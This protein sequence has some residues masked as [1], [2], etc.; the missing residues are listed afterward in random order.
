[1]ASLQTV[2][3]EMW[4]VASEDHRAGMAR[5]GIPTERAM[6]ISV[7]LLRKMARAY[8]NE[9]E[10]AIE[11]W[12]SGWHEARILAP[13]VADPNQT[14]SELVDRWTEAFDAWDIC[15]LCC[16]NLFRLTPFVYDKIYAYFPREE[17]FVRRTAFVLM[18]TLAVGDK[19]A[20]DE[21][22]QIILIGVEHDDSL[23]KS[24]ILDYENVR[25]C[26]NPI[27]TASLA[28]IEHYSLQTRRSEN[29]II[30]VGHVLPTKGIFELIEACKTIG[31]IQLH[32]IGKISETMNNNLIKLI[33]DISAEQC[34]KICGELS[35]DT[36]I[37]EMLSASVLALPS[38]T[39][40]FPNVILESMACGC[41]IIATP[42]GA[43]PEM[44]NM[45]SE[46]PCGIVVPVKNVSALHN[47][48]TTIINNKTQ[49]DSFAMRARK[50]VMQNYTT[51][52]VWE[53]LKSVWE[54]LI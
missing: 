32:I 53:N 12:N 49:A 48:I 38:Y 51:E 52:K 27:T 16:Q 19:A 47:A 14:T 23:E 15:D 18:A 2:L 40:G 7:P 26:P 35:H 9:H 25:Y 44:L 17:E 45:D 3:D 11:L 50:R 43:I 46:Q 20:E 30:F 4:A 33:H 41:P 22:F 8:R 54:G 39:E 6:G 42:V 21:R 10:L 34:I 36:V 24:G 31:N 37:K 5:F 28:Q 13:M 1:M 29:K